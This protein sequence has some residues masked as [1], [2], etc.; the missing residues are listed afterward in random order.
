LFGDFHHFTHLQYQVKTLKD[1]VKAFES[2]EK[3]RAMEVSFW[4][5]ISAKDQT[6]RKQTALIA[7]ADRQVV[8]M[9]KNWSM[10]FD[11]IEKAYAEELKEKDCQIN[12]LGARLLNAQI[13]SDELRDM[14]KAKTEELYQVKTE[15]EDAQ[16]KNSKLIA[17]IN[18]DYSNSAK[19]SSLKPNHKKIE[20]NREQTGKKPGAQPGHKGHKRKRLEP[21]N[22]ILIPAPEKY[23]NNPDYKL[24]GKTISKQLFNLRMFVSV[25]EYQ[26]PEFRHK[27]TGQRVHADFPNAV[28]DDVNYGGSIK[29]FLH[30][31][32]SYCCVSIDK[33]REF[34]SELTE[35]KLNISKGMING[36]NKEFNNKTQA[37]QKNAF[38]D[39]L[40]SPVMNVDN[41][42]ARVNGKSAFVFVC[43]TPE[44]ALYF[45][46]EHKGHKGVE[47]T[48]IKDFQHTLV[49]DH[50]RTFYHYGSNH[51]ECMVHILRY[52]L[53]SIE[54]ESH[55]TWNS[56]MRQLIREMIHYHK[57]LDPDKPLDIDKAEEFTQKYMDVLR[58]AEK[59]YEYEPPSRYY[60][61]GYNLFKRLHEF[62]KYH[63]LFLRQSSVPTNNSLAERLLRI[64]KRK[65]KQVMS[66]RCFESLD[67][68]CCT[69][70]MISLLR[71]NGENLFQEVTNIFDRKIPM[72]QQ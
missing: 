11:D 55:L 14:L 30:L 10:V 15:L 42:N 59:E 57:H 65:M 21:T 19:S 25:D 13:K 9:R 49:H 22:R 62:A 63:L 4:A 27:R 2:G 16:G 1:R 36:L 35:G 28:N 31:L 48:P 7:A 23:L 5:Q 8:T 72:V 43:A 47:G 39:L 33:C 12:T 26:T 3:Y 50:D 66:F 51:Q 64:F 58:L 68:L 40:L 69:L 44:K 60:K 18:R 52:L 46:R 67:V 34:L 61:D 29:A 37:D 70:G 32:N 38:D 17:Q 24:T 54:N 56:Q 71:T 45:A 6:I 41:T 53:D 20:N